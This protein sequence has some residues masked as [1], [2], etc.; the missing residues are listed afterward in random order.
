MRDIEDGEL[1]ETVK[2]IVSITSSKSAAS[3]ELAAPAAPIGLAMPAFSPARM[4]TLCLTVSSISASS[5]FR[6]SV[7]M[8]VCNLGVITTSR[9]SGK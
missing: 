6:L 2:H 5:M 4:L 3:A 7:S 1:E 8:L 9:I